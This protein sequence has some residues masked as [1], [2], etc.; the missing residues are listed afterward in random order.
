MVSLSNLSYVSFNVVYVGVESCIFYFAAFLGIMKDWF[1]NIVKY[2]DD[3]DKVEEKVEEKVDFDISH[4]FLPRT[5][6]N[7]N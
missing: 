6:Q 5:E 2:D 4:F 1:K 7:K 3:D